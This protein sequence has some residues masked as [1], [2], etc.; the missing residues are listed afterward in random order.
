[1]A[2]LLTQSEAAARQRLEQIASGL[3]DLP[4]GVGVHTAVGSPVDRIL[5]YVRDHRVDLVVVGTHGRGLVG[6]LLLGSVAERVIRRAGVPVLTVHGQPDPA[7][8]PA[9]S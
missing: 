9:R 5:D 7:E 4:A 2:D 6:H 3:E 8:R 1:M